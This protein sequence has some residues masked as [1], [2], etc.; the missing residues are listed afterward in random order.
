M[1]LFGLSAIEQELRPARAPALED[2]LILR[3]ARG[4]TQA[5]SELYL[6]AH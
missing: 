6:R 5:F 4:E 1:L 2:S 3:I